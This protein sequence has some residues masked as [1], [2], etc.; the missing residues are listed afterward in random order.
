MTFDTKVF[1]PA[2]PAREAMEFVG[3]GEDRIEPASRGASR[4]LGGGE[5]GDLRFFAGQADPDDEAHFTI[6]YEKGVTRGV[7][8]GRVVDGLNVKLTV[9]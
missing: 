6:G 5:A 2:T 9:R 4:W 3:M 1:T 7:V 8:D